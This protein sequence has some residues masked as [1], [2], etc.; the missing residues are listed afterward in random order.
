MCVPLIIPPIFSSS[1]F[2][3]AWW[4]CRCLPYDGTPRCPCAR[5][6]LEASRSDVSPEPPRHNTTACGKPADFCRLRCHLMSTEAR[7]TISNA[8]NTARLTSCKLLVC[9]PFFLL[10]R[11]HSLFKANG[12]CDHHFF[13]LTHAK[14][15]WMVG[16]VSEYNIFIDL[17]LGTL[18]THSVQALQRTLW[19]FFRQNVFRLHELWLKGRHEI[20]PCF[21]PSKW[22]IF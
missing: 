1:V 22:P 18:W 3:S 9:W 8:W 20:N 6:R 10:K 21:L 14:Q 17:W 5:S 7:L 16:A 2:L 15:A 12:C 4:L 19:I 13:F 11:C